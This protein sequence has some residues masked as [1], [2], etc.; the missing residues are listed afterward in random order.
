MPEITPEVSFIAGFLSIVSPTNLLLVLF[1]LL[2]MIVESSR[3]VV[4]L[5][6]SSS[7]VIWV[8]AT[9]SFGFMAGTALHFFLVLPS[10]RTVIFWLSTSTIFL[11]GCVFFLWSLPKAPLI[12]QNARRLSLAA[13]IVTSPCLVGFAVGSSHNPTIGPFLGEILANLYS[14]ENFI[15]SLF[16]FLIFQ[17]GFLFCLFASLPFQCLLARWMR[18][19]SGSLPAVLRMEGIALIVMSGIFATGYW[20]DIQY[21]LIDVSL[22]N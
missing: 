22:L 8:T 1:C 2:Y 9:F 11:C 17:T 18:E 14:D 20:S 6:A 7:V 10:V 3:R 16:D 13:V 4:N 15:R 12:F 19:F 21:F 5:G